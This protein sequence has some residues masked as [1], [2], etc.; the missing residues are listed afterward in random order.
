MVLD[1]EVSSSQVM[2][3]DIENPPQVVEVGSE[4]GWESRRRCKARAKGKHLIM[5]EE[6]EKGLGVTMKKPIHKSIITESSKEKR[7]AR[8]NST[9]KKQLEDLTQQMLLDQCAANE[10]IDKILSK[11]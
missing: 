10:Q 8:E 9:L 11:W 4:A 7:L 1:E 3:L 6:P 5:S 2:V